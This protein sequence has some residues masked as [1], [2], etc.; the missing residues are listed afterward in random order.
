MAH[1]LPPGHKEAR[2]TDAIVAI[3]EQADLVAL[4]LLAPKKDMKRMPQ[5]AEPT[6][7][8]ISHFGLPVWA[9]AEYARTMK[10]QSVPKKSLVRGL[11]LVVR[12]KI[13]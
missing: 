10:I 2:P 3:E 12:K 4:E 6:Q 1:P 5:C 13:L 7:Y 9:A 11:E 8:L